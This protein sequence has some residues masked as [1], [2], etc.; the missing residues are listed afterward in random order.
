[1]F[2]TLRT[3]LSA[4]SARADAHVKD[5]FAID[6]ID[7][8]VRETEAGLKAAKLSLAQLIQRER[9]EVQFLETLQTEVKT[10]ETRARAALDAEQTDL[11]TE[12][13]QAIAN[14]ENELAIRKTTVQRLQ[15]KITRLQSSVKTGHRKVVELKQGAISAK[16]IRGEQSAL[17]GYKKSNPS[18]SAQ[19][20]QELINSVIGED[21]PFEMADIMS[22]IDAE[23]TGE[24]LHDRM[25]AKGFGAAT[26][27]N[28][29]DVLKRLKS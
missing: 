7:Q 4:S 24:T 25:A 3:L 6:L 12:A 21:D 9:T 27:A 20:A 10:L 15:V 22:D 29:D 11:A 2:N 17:M 8:K 14:I 28:A 23:L 18:Q 1:M 13:A 19:E 26:K 16:A 5:V